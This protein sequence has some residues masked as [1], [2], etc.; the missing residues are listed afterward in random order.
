MSSPRNQKETI[1]EE[2]KSEEDMYNIKIFRRTLENNTHE[3]IED[4]KIKK[5]TSW[6]KS[7]KK[8]FQS[9]ILNILTLGILHLFSLCYPNLYIKLYCNRRK[10]KECDFF[11]VEDIYGQ[12]TLCKKIYKKDKTQNNINFNSDSTKEGIMSSSL[13]NYSGKLKKNFTKNLTYSFV[14]RS[15]T[16]EYDEV[17]NEIIPVYIN[18][19]NLTC[20]DIFHYFSEGLSSEGIIKIF[21]NRYG[22]NEYALNFQMLYLYFLNIELPYLILV[23][24][25]GIIELG[26]SDYISFIAKTVILIILLS[27]EFINMKIN[28]Y[29]IYKSENTLDGEKVKIRVKRSHKFDEKS[30]LFCLIDNID[31][32]PGDIIFLKSNDIVPCDCL[33]LEGECMANSNSLTGNLNIFRKV[34]LENKN[35]NFNYKKNKENILYH[36]MKIVKTYSNLKKEYISALCL[37]TGPNTF[38]AN[39]YSNAIYFFERNKQYRNTFSFFGDDRKS[40]LFIILSIFLISIICGLIYV[41]LIMTNISEILDIKKSKTGKIFITILIRVIC[42]SFMPMYYLINSIIILLGIIKLKNENV[43]TFEKSKILY[44]STIDTLFISKTGTLC[45]GKFEI[46]GYHPIYV[47][48]HNSNN[49]FFRTYGVNQNKEI[50]LQLVKY[51]KDYLNKMKEK[52]NINNNSIM[53]DYNNFNNEKANLKSYEYSTL[54]LECLLSCNNLEKYGMEVFGNSIDSEIFRAMKWD[55]KADNNFNSNFINPDDFPYRKTENSSNFSNINSGVKVINDIFPNNYYKIT[56]SMKTENTLPEIKTSDNSTNTKNN[57]RLSIYEEEKSLHRDS[58]FTNSNNLIEADISQSHINSYKLR[59]YKRFIKEGAFSSSSITYNFITKELRFNTKGIPEDILDKCNP[60]TI[61]ENFDKIIP[62]YRRK[63]FIVII[64]AGRKINMEQYSDMD[65]EDKYMNDLTFYGFVTLK[66]KLKTEVVYALNELRMFNI[67]FV[68]STGDD[69]YNTL[70][71]GFESTIL[72]NKDIYS[73]DKDKEKNRIV[74]KKIYSSNNNSTKNDEENNNNQNNDNNINN[75]PEKYSRFSKNYLKSIDKSFK[76]KQSK[77]FD[78]TDSNFNTFLKPDKK[79]DQLNLDPN[80]ST[81]NINNP[82]ESPAPKTRN[83]KRI[84]NNGMASTSKEF[85][86]QNDPK[87][88]IVVSNK[89]LKKK[90]QMSRKNLNSFD[91]NNIESSKKI[92]SFVSRKNMSKYSQDTT[93]MLGMNEKNPT[94]YYYQGIF[95]DHKELTEDCIYCISGSVFDFLYQIKT[96]KHAKIL[97]DKIHEKCRIFYNMSSLSKSRVIDYYREYPDDCICSIG[98]CQSDIDPIITSN[99]GINLQPPRNYNTILAHFYSPDANLLTIKK[100]IMGGRAIKENHLLMK[101]SCSIYT[102]IINA[103]I[104]CCFIRQMDV[105]QGQLNILELGFLFLSITAFTSKVDDNEGSN[106][107]IQ[108]K[109]LYVCHYICQITGLVIIKCSG[110][111]FHAISFNTNNFL[112]KTDIDKIYSTFF[113]TFCIEQLF[114]TIVV[115]NLICFYRKSWFFN[116]AFII[117]I[118]IIFA[119]FVTIITLNNSNYKVDIFGILYFEFFENIVDAYDENNKIDCFLVCFI[120]FILSIVYSRIVYYIFEIL[121][122]KIPKNNKK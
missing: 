116:T 52:S 5:V 2:I 118:L 88:S 76:L 34:S 114:S 20:K 111:Y 58:L 97:L 94:L 38:K 32:L 54:F 57:R 92:F 47:S 110:I 91:F 95:E 90:L 63:G 39:M 68:I 86:N 51:Y 3:V 25:I 104:L 101:I 28:I 50:N 119:Y 29:D 9:L 85:L 60:S 55:I 45:E 30:E 121:S 31:L 109:K 15:V 4:T 17:S 26:L 107:L 42:K 11:L 24:I 16:Y 100:I 18:L 62:L 40:V 53:F 102:L 14:Y 56:E 87:N 84:Y 65:H 71:V 33:I 19:L 81:T 122:K 36:G 37:N 43:F 113:F 73:F 89:Q 7:Q 69:I 41:F 105:V 64:C 72:D 8:F 67:N 98:E 21:Q 48:H 108:R 27:A 6:R 79:I 96:K 117:I 93:T 75:T 99:I 44:S 103:Y 80:N 59:I 112:A 70:P 49:L 120:D 12:L 23:I 66:N 10:P 13:S 82:N 106:C 61:P 83:I 78:N 46:N 22:K 1:K 35:E 74:I 77:I 115:L